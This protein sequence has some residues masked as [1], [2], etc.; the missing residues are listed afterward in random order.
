MPATATANHAAVVDTT[1]SANAAHRPVPLGNVI[2]TDTLLAPRIRTNREV[3]IPSQFRHLEETNRLRNFER[4]AGT[5][6][7]PFDG[8]YFNDS[9]VYKWLEA[10]ASTIAASRD[11]DHTDVLAMIDTCIA[12]IEGAQDTD[13]YLNTYFSVDRVHERWSNL[14][15]LHELY[16]AG[17]FIQAAIALHRATGDSRLMTVATKLADLIDTTF[18]PAGDGKRE[19]VDG[20]EEIELALVELYRETGEQRYLNL[21]RFFIDIR[22]TGTIGGSAYHQ[23]A[24]PVRKQSAMVGHAVRAVY[25]NAGAA[26]VMLEGEDPALWLALDRMWTNMTTRR[27]YVSGGIGSRWEG[28]AFGD[29]FELP[30][31]RA[32]TESCAAIGAI[33]WA[34]RMLCHR[35]ED[36][37]R[38][39]DWIEH[40][41]YN[42]LLPGLSLDGQ[43]Y[44]YQNPLENDGAHRRQPWFGCACCPPNIARL[45]A[46]LPGYVNSVTTRRFPESDEQHDTVWVHLFADSTAT[47]PLHAGG[48]V[49]LR[50]R[51]RYPWDGQV[52]VAIEALHEAGDFTLQVRVPG[53]AEGATVSV[54]GERQPA[55]E[56]ARGQYAT[57][58]RTWRVGDVV[59][60]ILPMPVRRVI[61]HPRIAANTDR[62][63]LLRGP[64]LYC[65]EA[66]DNPVGDVRDY[67]LPDDAHLV[68]ASRPDLLGGIVVI[69]ADGERAAADP[70]WERALYQP[71][72]EVRRPANTGDLAI[73]AIPYH[74][75][76]NR[77]AGPMAV[78]LRRNHS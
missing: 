50:Q 46:Q 4:V 38:Y 57:I 48:S 2:L 36:N 31:D 74:L 37:S 61:A 71:L 39:A 7:A 73:T 24:T 77:G 15:D 22:G 12:L 52:E 44:F 10:V 1:A 5:V 33:M 75:W 21:A 72:D 6:D 69:T 78:W 56:A 63:A 60:L 68:A 32:Y 23:D 65:I 16:C 20:H 76:A 51:T 66:A 27:S 53:W 29:D 14:R 8:I 67:V 40:A 34:W 42:A 25:L 70:A 47:I 54:N 13:G 45:L 28:E 11:V 18:G 55:S 35:A 58:R 3:T 49:T 30:N 17:H 62:V 59:S 41:L 43:A 9:D 64:L 26:D 19:Q